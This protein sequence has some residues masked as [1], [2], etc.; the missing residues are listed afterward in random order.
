MSPQAKAATSTDATSNTTGRFTVQLPSELRGKIDALGKEATRGVREA[1]GI[2]VELSMAQ[3]VAGVITAQYDVM[4][5]RHE[6]A[7]ATNDTPAE[8]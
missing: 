5:E 8:S 1:M 4:T 6:Q 3:V 2:D 7:A